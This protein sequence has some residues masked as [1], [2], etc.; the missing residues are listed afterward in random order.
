MNLKFES[1]V[2]ILRKIIQL[3]AIIILKSTNEYD[4][5][6][7]SKKGCKMDLYLAM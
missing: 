5:K 6:I 4:Q 3:N 2:Q 1:I 7:I